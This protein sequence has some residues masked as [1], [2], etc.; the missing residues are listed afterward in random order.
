[1]KILNILLLI[2]FIII[3]SKSDYTK[4]FTKELKN[5]ETIENKEK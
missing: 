4:A 3:F 2:F 5:K 1:M